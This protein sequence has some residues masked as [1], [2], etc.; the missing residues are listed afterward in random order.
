MLRRID[1]VDPP[2]NRRC[3]GML[4]MRGGVDAAAMPEMT[5]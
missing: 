1:I 3:L 5:A 4:F 2:P